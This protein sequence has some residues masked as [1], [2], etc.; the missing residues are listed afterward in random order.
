MQKILNYPMGIVHSVIWLR[1]PKSG[2]VSAMIAA[3]TAKRMAVSSFP[4]ASCPNAKEVG[5]LLY[6]YTRF[7][8][9][10]TLYTGVRRIPR[11][12]CGSRRPGARSAGPIPPWPRRKQRCPGSPAERCYTEYNWQLWPAQFGFCWRRFL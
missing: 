4:F 7:P 2:P 12:V 3:K 9:P 10:T 5:P 11:A 8:L 1:K 6:L